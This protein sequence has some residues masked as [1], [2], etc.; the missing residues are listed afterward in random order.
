MDVPNL[1]AI[2]TESF[3]WFKNE[4][5][6]QAFA[7]VCPIENNTGDMCVEFGKH[8]FGEPKYTVDECKEKDVSYQAPLFVEIRFINRE[9][10]EIKEQEVFMGDFPLMT[11]RGTFI[12]NGTERVVVSQLVRS[13]GVYF[14][15]ERDK[16]SDKTIYNA[17]VIPSRGAWLEFE[18][19]K[20]DLLSVRIDR[21]RKQPAT[22]LVRALGLAETREEIIELLGS[23]EMVL[24][25][26]DRDPATTK[27]E[28]LI[29]LY[30][31]FRPGEPPTIDSARTLLE[32]LFFNPQR[33]DLAKVGRYKMDKKLGFTPEENDSST[34]TDEDIIRTMRYIIGLHN[35]DEGFATDDI[36]HF[37]NRRIRSVGELIQ[38]QFRIGLSR[39]ERVVRERMSM[40]EPDEITPQSLVNI[41]PIVAAI[42]EFFGSSQLSQFMDQ[43]NPAAGITHKR[44]LSALGPGGLSRERAGF[45]VRDVHTSH[46][47]RMCPIETPEGP[48]IGLIGSLAAYGR[49]NPYGFIETPYRRVVDG[50]VTDDIDYLTA[51][52]E[53]N[54][55]I[56][57]ANDL[58]DLETR[59]FGYT[60]EDGV[61]HKSTRVLARTTDTNGVF[62]EAMDVPPEQVDYMDVSPRQ[63]TSVATSLIPFLE[64]DDANR[65]LMGSNMQRQAVPLL[66]PS[67]PLVGTGI[68]HRIAVDSGEILVAQRPGVVDYVDGQTIIILNDDGEYDEYLIPKFQRSN[69]SGCINHRPIVRKG[70]EVQPG[71]VLAD[72]PSCDGG[73]LALGQN[74]MIAYMPWEGYNYEDAIIVSERV[75]A[76]DLLTSIHISEY[77]V[78]ARDTKL[79][80]EEITREIPNISEDMISDLDADGIIR[81]GAEVFPGDVLVGKV[82]PKGETELTAE[83]RLLR[84]IFGEKAREV[85]DTS[86]KVPHGSGGRVIGIY[87]TSREN[88]DDLAPGVNELVR[89]YVAQKRKVQQ[90]DKLSGRHGNKGVIS[91]VLPVE[92][93]PYLADGTPIDVILNPLGVPSRMNVGQLLENH[94]GWAAKWGWSDAEDTTEVVEGPIHVAT[95]VFDGATE[96]EISDAIVKANRNLINI[97]HAK[98]GDMARD[99]LV[100]QLTP[101]GKTWLYDGRTG[102]KFREPITVGQTY[103]LKL[104]HMVDDKIHARSTGPYSLI[105]QQPLGGKAQFGGQRFGEMEV[106]ALYAYGAS[107][108]LQEILTVKSDDTSG[109]VKSYEAIVKGE[110]IPAPEVPESFKVLV[111]EMKSLCLNIELEGHDMQPISEDEHDDIDVD[112]ALYAALAADAKKTEDE[113]ANAIDAIA[114]ELGD[115]MSG[116]ESDLNTDLIGGGEEA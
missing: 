107:N 100:P 92:D 30:K 62:G 28:S 24:R 2:Q 51:D 42:K 44:R 16:T 18:T 11:P 73:E 4:G 98:Y 46:Y 60:D 57:Q 26:L 65:A 97:N 71:D 45:E 27:E 53:E 77:E 70:D 64:H 86:L 41:R 74:L 5:L 13:P 35:G 7:D 72:G 22:L 101:T 29:E 14:A 67:A 19:D 8:H 110:N 80:P 37:G 38:N 93:M 85:R 96:E 9:T 3:D 102:E 78:D 68:E 50:K 90:G 76:E 89:I 59:E 55:T 88:D 17:K 34:L 116:L 54:F 39:M 43:T 115:L 6:A 82:T 106:W 15:S 112:Q 114:A 23:S 99:E 40:Q 58:F 10:G 113:E 109:R 25:T 111:K 66:R 31:R 91:R 69:Q 63:M 61:F 52:E 56:A 33:Y 20:R 47:G 48:N 87:R 94:L 32:G 83:E 49:I 79:G 21:K 108:V 36:D 105:T 95:P 104:G 81:V 75:V 1:I 103:I 12:I 84:A